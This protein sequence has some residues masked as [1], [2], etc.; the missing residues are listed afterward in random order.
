MSR[1]TDAKCRLC[2]REGIPLFLKGHRCLTG[3]C[4][5]KRRESTPGQHSWRKG[6]RSDYGERLREKQKLKRYY[7]VIDEQFRRLFAL[8]ERQKGN[9]GE[10]LIVLLERRLDNAVYSMGF[11]LSRASARQLIRHG[12]VTVNGRRV[13]IPSQLVVAGDE[14]APADKERAKKLVVEAI[15]QTRSRQVP[16]WLEVSADPPKGRVVQLPRRD[17]LTALEVNELFVVEVMKR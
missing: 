9:T 11:A 17:D 7:G 5:V 16:S 13:N 12:H 1:E 3:K 10:N 2:R 8:A 14:I 15:E 6:R 4:A